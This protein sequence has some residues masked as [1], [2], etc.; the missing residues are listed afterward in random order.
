[1][2]SSG[3]PASTGSSTSPGRPVDGPAPEADH[4]RPDQ[5]F[6]LRTVL[7]EEDDDRALVRRCRDGDRGAFNQ[8]VIRYQKPVYNAALRMLRNPE[9]ARDVAQT[10]FL[11]VFERLGQYDE[12][13]RFYSWI[14]R[15]ALNESIN[16]LGRSKPL[17]AISG[18]EVDEAPGPDRQLES[19]Q[20]N[21]AIE[22]ALTRIQPDHRAVIVLRHLLHLSY[23]DMGQILELPE[24]TVKSRLFT[25]RQL[26]RDLL[27]KEGVV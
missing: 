3:T 4:S 7:V 6:A 25:A 1:M 27:L 17:E 12:K 8:L 10:V 21:R 24:K 26:L 9:D 23:Q 16:T 5:P 2:T 18:T 11:K 22:Q 15:I 20:T 19:E 13:S 14:Y